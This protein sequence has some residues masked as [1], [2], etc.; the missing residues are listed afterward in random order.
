MICP[1]C[2]M[3]ND[4]FQTVCINCG[5]P[6]TPGYMMCPECGK[7]IKEGSKI[8]PR[9][10]SAIFEK[11][12]VVENKVEHTAIT[13]KYV[14]K[15]PLSFPSI[16]AIMLFMFYSLGY[17]IVTFIVRIESEY[18][19]IG[20]LRIIYLL[21]TTE[22]RP[23]VLTLLSILAFATF[24]SRITANRL[25]E[26]EKLEERLVQL[27]C[28]LL[29]DVTSFF[30]YFLVSFWPTMFKVNTPVYYV[31]GSIGIFILIIAILSLPLFYKKARVRTR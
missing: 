30:T 27:K 21:F 12:N 5:E 17:N 29:A 15:A 10:K 14:I 3:A 6:L 13:P 16:L 19:D 18:G 22:I 1:K 2:G 23:I 25:K 8:C 11:V 9:C 28:L 24:L 4:N 20:I 26:K 7:V 31:G